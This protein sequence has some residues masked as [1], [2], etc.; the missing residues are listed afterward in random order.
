MKHRLFLGDETVQGNPLAHYIRFVIYLYIFWLLISGSLQVKFLIMG[1]V[2]CLIIAWVCTPLFMI[3]NISHT[4]K[5]FLLGIPLHR[6][7]GYA[8][9][10]VKEMILANVD[11]IKATWKK[12]LPIEPELLHFYVSMDNPVALSLLAN[13]I[14]L[15]PGTITLNV[16][17]DNIYEI[18]ALTPGA[19]EGIRSGSMAIKVAK[20]F[21]VEAGFEM[22]PTPCPDCPICKK[23]KE[24]ETCA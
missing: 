9:W 1:A 18:H 14:T 24:D 3:D 7:I 13:S 22:L 10:V 5:Y 8:I 16:S 11:V 2:S 4:K 17:R 6:L 23:V 12:N 21:G 19:A 20:L 15:T